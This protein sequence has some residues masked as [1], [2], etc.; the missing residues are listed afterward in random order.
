MADF[1]TFG[2]KEDAAKFGFDSEDVGMRSEMDGGYVLTRPRHT[3]KP[4]RTFKTGFTGIS[5]A[6]FNTFLTFWEE[7][8]TYKAFNYT[9]PISGEIVNVRLQKKPTWAYKGIG[10]TFL[11]DI[12]EIYLEEV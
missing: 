9:V 4:R 12:D 8:G 3:R 11:W 7:H 6:N 2:G 1:P 10:Q 5:Q